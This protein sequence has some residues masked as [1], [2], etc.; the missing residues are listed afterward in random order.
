MMEAERQGR[1]R[2][3]ESTFTR[4]EAQPQNLTAISSNPLW[5]SQTPMTGVWSR[6][7]TDHLAFHFESHMLQLPIAILRLS[8]VLSNEFLSHIGLDSSL[9]N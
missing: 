6:L 3:R 8:L 2:K 4:R 5:L 7:C 1:G 9:G